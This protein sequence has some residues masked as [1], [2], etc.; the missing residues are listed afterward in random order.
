MLP[1][2]GKHS[3]Q[4]LFQPGSAVACAIQI[5]Q[6]ML[7]Q[8]HRR[9]PPGSGVAG[10]SKASGVAV[11]LQQ[12]R[13]GA[14]AAAVQKCLPGGIGAGIQAVVIALPTATAAV[15]AILQPGKRPPL[16]IVKAAPPGG[17]LQGD[18]A[19]RRRPRGIG[20]VQ[21]QQIQPAQHHHK[22]QQQGGIHR[23]HPF[24]GHSHAPFPC[25]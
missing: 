7:T 6:Q 11:R 9:I 8:R 20:W 14:A 21:R 24:A 15:R 1:C 22:T 25:S 10:Q 4:R 13:S 16:C 5:A 19:L 2:A 12:K 18:R 3:V 17:Q 23:Q